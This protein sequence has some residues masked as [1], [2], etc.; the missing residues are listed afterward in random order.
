MVPRDHGTLRS[1]E[2]K[3]WHRTLLLR[4]NKSYIYIILF[5]IIKKNIYMTTS[6]YTCQFHPA[7]SFP[8]SFILYFSN[9]DLKLTTNNCH[10]HPSDS[11]LAYCQ[12]SGSCS[13]QG[14]FLSYTPFCLFCIVSSSLCC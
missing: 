13:C 14:C 4:F 6:V 1:F 10:S 5:L 12:P 9:F 2:G 11:T 7:T 3:C 8:L